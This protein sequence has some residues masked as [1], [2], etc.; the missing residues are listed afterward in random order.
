MESIRK[1]VQRSA[2]RMIADEYALILDAELS[3]YYLIDTIVNQLP[4][5]IEHL[6]QLRAYGTDILA[7]K[8]ITAQQK[9][10]IN[11]LIGGLDDAL[12]IF[13][14]NLDKTGRYNPA[15]QGLISAISRDIIDSAQQITGLVT[16]DILTGHFAALPS[17]FFKLSTAAIDQSYAQLHEALSPAAE[18]LLKARIAQAES[19]LYFSVGIA[20][21]LLLMVAYFSLGISHAV[22]GHI[23]SLVRLA[24]A[25]TAGNLDERVD[26]DTSDELGQV[27]ECFNQMVCGFNL[28]LEASRR[29][30]ARL[31]D[32]SAHLEERVKERT[33]ELEL[34]Q[35]E[36]E[37][38]LRRNQALMMTSLEG[39]HVM[40]IQGNLGL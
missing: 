19:T 3:T 2:S 20:T 35:R 21:L 11:I 30:E 10:E 36:T 40:D 31:Q 23:R 8:Q 18:T 28:L 24:Q 16:S 4:H 13:R 38:L 12:G 7:S 9:I 27:G 1:Y 22:V 17:D 26:I 29:K 39:V 25:I 37:V 34:A 15:L 5:T 6:G 14:T 32:L 33:V